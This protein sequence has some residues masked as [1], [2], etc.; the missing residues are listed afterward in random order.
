MRKP[1]QHSRRRHRGQRGNA[2]LVSLIALTGLGTLG[3]ITVLS[4]SGGFS[5]STADRSHAIA[6]YAAESGITVGMRYLGLPTLDYDDTPST[7]RRFSYILVPGKDNYYDLPGLP[8]NRMLPGNSQNLFSPSMKA[9]YDVRV[10][11][12][13]TDPMINDTNDFEDS[14]G[15]IILTSTGYGPNRAT[16]TIEAELFYDEVPNERFVVLSWREVE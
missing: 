10:K 7:G 4:V 3:I 11:N 8:G 5:A 2:L 12:N 14:D 6:V 1:T 13:P 15:R 16:A 9:W